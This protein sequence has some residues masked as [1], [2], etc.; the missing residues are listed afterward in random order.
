MATHSSILALEYPMDRGAWQATVHWITKSWIQLSDISDI[1][2]SQIYLTDRYIY[3]WQYPWQ[4]SMWKWAFSEST[5]NSSLHR[6]KI[7]PPQATVSW[8]VACMSYTLIWG[9]VMWLALA[10][11]ILTHTMKQWEVWGMPVKLDPTLLHFC[12]HRS[13]AHPG[14]TER[15]M[16]QTWPDLEPGTK[17]L[18]IIWGQLNPNQLQTHMREN[19]VTQH[20]WYAS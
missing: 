15:C 1:S 16:L 8:W 2:D 4:C 20:Y 19:N 13:R 12:S 9:L 17:S 14:N 10:K 18:E 6:F 11:R 5:N 3:P 7:T